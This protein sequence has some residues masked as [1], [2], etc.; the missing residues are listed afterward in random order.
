MPILVRQIL[1][2][3]A[4]GTVAIVARVGEQRFVAL[5]AVGMLITQDVTLAR[6]RLVALPAAEVSQMPILG[7]GL[8]VLTALRFLRFLR[9]FR[10]LGHIGKLLDGGGGGA[11]AISIALALLDGHFLHLFHFLALLNRLLESVHGVIDW[12]RLFLPG[13]VRIDLISCFALQLKERER[14]SETERD[15]VEELLRPKTEVI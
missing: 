14:E 12:V 4:D 13:L 11:G 6:Q 7:H 8:R 2:V 9:F 1:G 15:A 10:L 3:D 5:D